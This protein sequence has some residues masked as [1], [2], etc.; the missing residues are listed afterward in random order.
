MMLVLTNHERF[1]ASIYGICPGFVHVKNTLTL[2]G[3]LIG[4]MISSA[5]ERNLHRR[6]TRPFPPLRVKGLAAEGAGL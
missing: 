6:E 1:T 5:V 2:F 4:R 3:D